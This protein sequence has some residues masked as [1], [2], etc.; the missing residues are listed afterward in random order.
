MFLMFQLV[1]LVELF[2][3][4][5]YSKGACSI[6]LTFIPSHLTPGSMRGGGARGQNV[7][8]IEHQYSKGL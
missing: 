2:N 5:K 6:G 1:T 8:H 7:V 4:E 3:H